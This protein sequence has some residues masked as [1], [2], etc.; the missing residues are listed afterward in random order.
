MYCKL[1]KLHLWNKM[2]LMQSKKAGIRMKSCE[3]Q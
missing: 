1:Q 2:S 3:D